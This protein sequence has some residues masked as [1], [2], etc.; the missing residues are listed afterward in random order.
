MS[1]AAAIFPFQPGRTLGWCVLAA[2]LCLDGPMAQGANE[3]VSREYQLKAAYLF[4]FTKF[5]AW[6]GPRF[7]DASSPIV[8][9]V[10]GRNPFGDELDK[11]VRGR[12]VDGRAI[13]VILVTNADELRTA[14]VLFVP[15]SEETRPELAAAVAQHLPVLTA[16]ESDTFT[17]DGGIITFTQADD[18][19]RFT[20]RL[21]A[22]ERA[23][24]KISAQLLKLAT[25][26]DRQP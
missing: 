11:I 18:K 8:I 9:G 16:G 4:N 2:V 12:T 26:V 17:R 23:G 6:P 3:P 13:R 10:L 5:V 14:H 1:S 19:L 20:I 25:A 15:A 21:A 22:A 7:E 24:L